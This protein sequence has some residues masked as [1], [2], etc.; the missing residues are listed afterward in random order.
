MSKFVTVVAHPTTGE[1]ITKSTSKPD[2]GTIRVDSETKSFENGFI[3]VSKRTAFLRGKL[4]DLESLGLTAGSKLP[5]QIVRQ[6]SFNPFFTAGENGAIKT[7]EPKINS[8]TKEVVLKDNR[9]VYMQ[10][11]FTQDLDASP[12]QWL[13]EEITVPVQEEGMV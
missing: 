8:T 12:Y 1:V 4:V 5:G 3:N 6:E 10:Q 7:Q 9:P 13:G 11:V 2:F